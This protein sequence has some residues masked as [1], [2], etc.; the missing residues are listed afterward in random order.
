MSKFS[1][2]KF[3]PKYTVAVQSYFRTNTR[4][5][6]EFISCKT[7]YCLIQN[8]QVKDNP[9]TETI[10]ITAQQEFKQAKILSSPATAFY[11]SN[12]STMYQQRHQLRKMK[13]NTSL[14]QFSTTFNGLCNHV[15]FQIISYSFLYLGRF[16][17]FEIVKIFQ[18]S[19]GIED[20]IQSAQ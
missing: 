9:G 8:Y 10:T 14:K 12:H 18:S 7:N 11:R 3:R 20:D 13:E 4:K 6:L 1:S 16:F 5:L 15:N 2:V 19:A 17:I